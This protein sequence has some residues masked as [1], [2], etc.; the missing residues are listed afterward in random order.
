M[1]SFSCQFTSFIDRIWAR[2]YGLS[3]F[4]FN[5]CSFYSVEILEENINQIRDCLRL[6][7]FDPVFKDLIASMK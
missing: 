3:D 4:V 1:G 5:S 7:K 6:D 2:I